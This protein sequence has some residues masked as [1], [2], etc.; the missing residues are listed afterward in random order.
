MTPDAHRATQNLGR[1]P[2]R[3]LGEYTI[4]DPIARGGT[5]NVYLAEHSVTKERVALKMLAP[6]F[7]DS[8]ELA[9]RMHAEYA[10]SRRVPHEG[11]VTVRGAEMTPSGIPYLVME[12]LDGENLGSLIER[13]HIETS[14]VLAIAVQVASA[15][16][17]LHAAG[18]IHC[19]LKPD[20][21]FVLYDETRDGAMPR[22]K[23]LD[24]GVATS[25]DAVPADDGTIAGTPS[26]MP[27]EQWRGR[28]TTKSDVYAL[29][30]M[31]YELCTGDVP[32]TGTLPQLMVMHQ[33]A[34]PTRPMA[35]VPGMSAE[36]DRIIMRALAKDPALRPTMAEMHTDLVRLAQWEKSRA[37][38]PSWRILRCNVL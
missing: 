12:L 26:Y 28:P 14:A 37:S 34:L 6:M 17:A 24:Y 32:F 21:V 38:I 2:R 33:D 11:L 31:L 5:A 18:V 10:I 19:D 1:S 27:V 30:C 20:N 36:L 7:A 25:V 35:R 23:V 13:G 3:R 4:I 16:M 9:A 8:P 29:G 22:V 15:V